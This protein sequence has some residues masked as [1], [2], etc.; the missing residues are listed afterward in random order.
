MTA[1]FN[2]LT[3]REEVKE[4]YDFIMLRDRRLPKMVIV[5]IFGSIMKHK[6]SLLKENRHRTYYRYTSSGEDKFPLVLGVKA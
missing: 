6:P 3:T 2:G 4:M 1:V 5:S